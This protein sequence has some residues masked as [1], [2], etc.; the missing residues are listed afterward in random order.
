MYILF[1]EVSIQVLLA[2]LNRLFSYCEILG[3]HPYILDSGPVYLFPL[4]VQDGW[5]KGHEL[6]S[7]YESSSHNQQLNNHQQG[8]PG[9]YQKQMFHVKRQEEVTA[10]W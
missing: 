5:V 6:I 8:D 4:P 9:T 7:S 3:V 10:I 1:G 2:C